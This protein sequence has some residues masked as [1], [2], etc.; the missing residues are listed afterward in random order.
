MD[1]WLAERE[2]G[3]QT[4]RNGNNNWKPNLDLIFLMQI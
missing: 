2:E 1:N 3:G 4:I